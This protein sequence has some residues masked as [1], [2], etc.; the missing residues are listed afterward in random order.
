MEA[1]KEGRRTQVTLMN[2][3]DRGGGG[4]EDEK[5]ERHTHVTQSED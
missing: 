5:D 3:G 4:G 2:Q 1:V